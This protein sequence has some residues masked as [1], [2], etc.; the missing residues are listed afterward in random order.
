MPYTS[1]YS[2]ELSP[3]RPYIP[4]R[5]I[6][7]E[8]SRSHFTADA[9]QRS[10]EKILAERRSLERFFNPGEL[11]TGG[12][13][14]TEDLH[15]GM[16]SQ[17]RS[18]KWLLSAGPDS[19]A[20]P[21]HAHVGV[22]DLPRLCDFIRSL[23]RGVTPDELGSSLSDLGAD[24]R[25]TDA[26]LTQGPDRAQR[27]PRWP[28]ADVP[29]IYRREHASLL[30]RSDTTTV[31]VDPQVLAGGWTTNHGRYPA[32]DLTQSVDAV[33]V[34]HHHSDHWHLPS[35]LHLAGPGTP[36]I[37]PD[38]PRP[39]MLCGERFTDSLAC[40]GQAATAGTWES[41]VTVGDIEIDILPFRGEQPTREDPGPPPDLRNWG[42]CFRV[43]TPHYSAVILADSG[44]DPSGDIC[45]SLEASVKRRGPVDFLLSNCRMFPEGI[46][47]GLPH[48][49]LALPFE[50][51]QQIFAERA[52][53][54]ALSMTFGPRGIADACAAA[55]ARYFLPYAHGFRG[56]GV[57]PTDDSPEASQLARVDEELRHR[58]AG[59]RVAGWYPGSSVALISGSMTLR[60]WGVRE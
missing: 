43:N 24:Q 13:G 10:L 55:Q 35:I 45:P 14:A 21:V 51:L 6:V 1:Q 3:A 47:L 12:F 37:V 15:Y 29:G 23:R 9:C 58:S 27:S 16:Y 57:D 25:L 52:R 42:N 44:V 11:R 39:N 30:F 59:T 49:A 26:L 20:P 33:L 28:P 53:G 56:I 50:R 2:V 22:A 48:Y 32:D 19:A 38:V 7:E 36:V 54:Q 40:V 18:W 17:S 41:T 31:V 46:N 4:F 5:R 8:W 34:T 60:H